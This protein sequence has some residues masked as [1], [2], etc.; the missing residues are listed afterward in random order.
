MKSY[1]E[2]E[3]LSEDK[4]KAKKFQVQS[5]HNTMVD[6]ELCRKGF[7]QPLIILVDST[8]AKYN[9]KKLHE[10]ICRIHCGNRTLV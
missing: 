1:L 3:R 9:M 2:L 5:P 7:V 4:T 6:I 8:E 10:G